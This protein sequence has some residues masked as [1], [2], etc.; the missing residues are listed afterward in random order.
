MSV[1]QILAE[2]FPGLLGDALARVLMRDHPGK[3]NGV[4]VDHDLAHPRPDFLALDA[5][6]CSF[7]G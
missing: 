3:I 7:L 2:D 5:H 4:A 6:A 1:S